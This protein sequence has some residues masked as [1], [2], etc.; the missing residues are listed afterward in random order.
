MKI[1]KAILIGFLSALFVGAAQAKEVDF[2]VVMEA[3]DINIPELKVEGVTIKNIREF[4]VLNEP[5]GLVVHKGDTVKITVDNKSPI[6]EGFAIDAYGIKETIKA[7]EKA[8][9]NLT[10]NKTGAFTIWCHLHPKGI[11]LPGSLN[12]VED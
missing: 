9:I 8:T 12:V 7:G 10:A 1:T 2:T 4:H 5:A 11:H 3:D 6:S